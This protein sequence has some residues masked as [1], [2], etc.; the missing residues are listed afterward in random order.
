MADFAKIVRDAIATANEVTK[1]LQPVAMV[2]HL[3]TSE[4]EGTKSF[5]APSPVSAIITW[6]QRHVRTLQ[7]ELSVSRST[8]EFLDIDELMIATN[9]EGIDDADLITLP[10]GT[11]GPILD[12]GGFIDKGT[13]R[14]FATKVFL[15]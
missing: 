8:V 11:T 6:E 4:Y 1:S 10:D 13:G 15:G 7:G 14:P 9:N 2:R 5:T 12:M 3:I